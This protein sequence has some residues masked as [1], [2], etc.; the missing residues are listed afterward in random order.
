MAL[1]HFVH[2]YCILEYFCPLPVNSQMVLLAAYAG[3]ICVACV[4]YSAWLLHC[5]SEQRCRMFA[6]FLSVPNGFIRALA[7]KQVGAAVGRML[8][9]HIV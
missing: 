7:S 5:V 9:R 6:I 2:F 4:L 3:A 1:V 8:C